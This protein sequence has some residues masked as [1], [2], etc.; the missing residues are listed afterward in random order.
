MFPIWSLRGQGQKGQCGPSEAGWAWG[1]KEE[2]GRGEGGR[3]ALDR[4]KDTDRQRLTR[5]ERGIQVKRGP[6][7]RGRRRGDEGERGP[8]GSRGRGGE[9]PGSRAGRGPS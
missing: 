1:I 7:G 4:V 5:Q 8:R 6:G 2:V 9:G 3:R